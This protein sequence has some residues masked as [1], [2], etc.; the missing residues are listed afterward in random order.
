M[1]GWRGGPA[2]CVCVYAC[3]EGDEVGSGGGSGGE[4]D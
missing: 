2:V 3:E 4:V 1:E